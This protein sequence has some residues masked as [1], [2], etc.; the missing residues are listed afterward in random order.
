MLDVGCWMLDVGTLFFQLEP[1]ISGIQHSTSNV[2]LSSLR[3]DDAVTFHGHGKRQY[4]PNHFPEFIANSST[5]QC[6]AQEV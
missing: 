5:I 1:G 4:V 6:L 2:Q 3:M